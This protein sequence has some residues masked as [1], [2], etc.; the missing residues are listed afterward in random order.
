MRIP[1]KLVA[2]VGAA[3]AAGVTVAAL[4]L[5]PQ[6]MAA[7]SVDESGPN[8]VAC[9][10]ASAAVL[11]AAIKANA[12]ADEIQAGQDQ[13][14]KD[15][16]DKADA[17]QAAYDLAYKAYQAVPNDANLKALQAGQDA[18]DA[19]LKN[20]SN[21]P[22]VP[23]DQKAALA[24]L[25]AELKVAIDKSERACQ[26]VPPTVTMTPSPSAVP[27]LY[28]DCAAVRAAGKAPL[29]RDADGY[30]PALD[31][32]SDGLACEDVEGVAPAP[33]I[34]TGIDTGRA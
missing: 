14:V 20:L 24:K 31:S 8:S 2:G 27:P 32:D 5:A 9:A 11:S 3:V 4:V 25:Q 17:A 30:R 19:A 16:K 12:M 29:G 22:G 18:L 10:Q 34:P 23:A 6:A 7:P 13:I 1:V 28:A 33:R 15:L 26:F 21:A